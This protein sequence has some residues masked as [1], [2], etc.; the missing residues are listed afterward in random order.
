M[1]KESAT[2]L[3]S[4][5]AEHVALSSVA[6]E[7]KCLRMLLKEILHLELPYIERNSTLG[8]T[9]DLDGR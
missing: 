6:M 7:I 2:L 1:K 3:H 5:E 8:I 9:R 4:T